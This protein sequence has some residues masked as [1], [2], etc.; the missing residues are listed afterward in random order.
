MDRINPIQTWDSELTCLHQSKLCTQSRNEK[1]SVETERLFSSVDQTWTKCEKEES[2]GRHGH[3]KWFRCS[4]W[5]LY[6]FVAWKHPHVSRYTKETETTQKSPE[7]A[8]TEKRNNQRK[9]ETHSPTRSISSFSGT[10]HCKCSLQLPQEIIKNG[11]LQGKC[12]GS[13]LCVS[14]LYF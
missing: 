7:I 2:L 3:Q 4:S 6:Q 11:I 8:R 13:T 10:T 12:S 5:D 14:T 9:K 1:S